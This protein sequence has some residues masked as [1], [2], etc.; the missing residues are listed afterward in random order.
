[1]CLTYCHI[2]GIVYDSD[3]DE[4]CGVCGYNLPD[5]RDCACCTHCEGNGTCALTHSPTPARGWCCHHNVKLSTGEVAI[6]QADVRGTLRF[7]GVP[8]VFDLYDAIYAA[9]EDKEDR[10]TID[11]DSLATPIT[12]GIPTVHWDVGEDED[13]GLVFEDVELPEAETRLLL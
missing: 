4:V 6:S 13:E 3:T 10:Y 8:D 11:L 5:G 9:D 7:V 1:M 12:Y 2:R